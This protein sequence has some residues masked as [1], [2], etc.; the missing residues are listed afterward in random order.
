MG[1]I[2]GMES[3]QTFGRKKTAVAI[4]H[5]KKGKGLIKLNGSPLELMKPEVLLYK[6][7]EPIKLLGIQYYSDLDI[8]IRAN[9]GGHVSRAYAIRQAIAKAVVAF[10]QK[11]VDEESKHSIKEKFLSFD[12]TL[13][14]SDHRRCEPKKFGGRG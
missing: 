10:Y 2:L 8:R 11:Y 12:R 9:G 14:V 1:Y 13:L 4:A 7:F 3:V 5:C 6:V